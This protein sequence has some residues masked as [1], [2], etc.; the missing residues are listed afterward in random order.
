MRLE[1]R[2]G[3]EVGELRHVGDY[4]SGK[5]AIF[6]DTFGAESAREDGGV[7]VPIAPNEKRTDIKFP[8]GV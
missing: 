5:V 3:Q 8:K 2:D 1:F 6:L 4:F 7:D